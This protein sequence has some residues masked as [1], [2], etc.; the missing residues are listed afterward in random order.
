MLPQKLNLPGD[1]RRLLKLYKAL[2]AQGRDSLLAF[3]EFLLQRDTEQSDQ[4]VVKAE[5]ELLP[6]AEGESVV[7]A[8][9]RLSASY[10]MLDRSML[11]TKTSSLMTAHIMHGRPAHDVIDELEALFAG[12]YETY[13]TATE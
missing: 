8:I 11:L 12:Y 10:P 1:Q 5:A 13:R 2:D 4:P 9:K 6:R 3:A 7:G